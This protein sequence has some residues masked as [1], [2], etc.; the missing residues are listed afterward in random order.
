MLP[1]WAVYYVYYFK[2][3]LQFEGGEDIEFKDVFRKSV[4]DYESMDIFGSGHFFTGS[5]G[6][7][8]K[9]HFLVGK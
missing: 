9:E 8:L 3:R 1:L 7:G 5:E 6:A 2:N 4:H